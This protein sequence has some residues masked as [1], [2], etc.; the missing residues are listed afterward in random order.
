MT[1]QEIKK[2]LKFKF[3]KTQRVYEVIR[4]SDV[5]V[6]YKFED[7]EST[8]VWRK[9]KTTFLIKFNLGYEKL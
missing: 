5:S 4:I 9:S 2:G 8:S 1:I 7:I 3:T 6:W